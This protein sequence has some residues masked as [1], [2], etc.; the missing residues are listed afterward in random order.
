MLHGELKSFNSVL[1]IDFEQPPMKLV[2]LKKMSVL[3]F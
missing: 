2:S 3:S 1:G